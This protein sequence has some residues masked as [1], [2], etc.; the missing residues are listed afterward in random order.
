M[1][2]VQRILIRIVIHVAKT[3]DGALRQQNRFGIAI[4]G[5]PVQVPVR[6]MNQRLLRTVRQS[7][8]GL[9]I[10]AEIMRMRI[11]REK[12]NID[13]KR[14]VIGDQEIFVAGRNVKF[15][16]ILQLEQH[17]Q[18]GCGM[19]REIKAD[20]R[21]N[22][23]G[24]TGGLQ[25]R[26]E[27]KI[28]AFIQSEAPFLPA[29]GKEQCLASRKASDCR[30]RR[31]VTRYGSPFHQTGAGRGF[32]PS[33]RSFAVDQNIGVMHETFIA[34]TNFDCFHPARSESEGGR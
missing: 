24:F 10:F 22:H 4:D 16:I 21:L 20:A 5:L 1:V 17:G 18:L 14:E 9:N 19:R 25:V 23:S 26:I 27:N 7:S 13:G 6:N 32:A 29:Q 31:P 8:E 2:R 12:I 30:D 3:D 28:C 33:R 15:G 11:D 34:G